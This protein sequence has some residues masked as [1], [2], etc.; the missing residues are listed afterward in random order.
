MLVDKL[1]Q[2]NKST[3]RLK[4]IVSILN[5]LQVGDNCLLSIH[6]RSRHKQ[7]SRLVDFNRHKAVATA[8]TYYP[9]QINE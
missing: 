9:Y 4:P 6:S 1:E 7:G 8:S 2:F 5:R 3:Y